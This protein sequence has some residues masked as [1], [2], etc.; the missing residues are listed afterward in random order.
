LIQLKQT[1]VLCYQSP[2]APQAQEIGQVLRGASEQEG[3]PQ[4]A[5]QVRFEPIAAKGSID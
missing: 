3:S 2:E 1:E 5:Q 4:Y